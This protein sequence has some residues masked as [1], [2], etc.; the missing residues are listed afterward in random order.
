MS[1]KKIVV[2]LLLILSTTLI[3]FTTSCDNDTGSDISDDNPSNTVGPTD[4]IESERKLYTVKVFSEGG[5]ALT[6]IEVFIYTDNTLKELVWVAKT[7]SEGAVSFT[8]SINANAVILLKNVPS[9]YEYKNEY[10]IEG[11]ITTIKLST[12]LIKLEDM[13]A[14]SFK[15]GDII[16]DFQFKDTD[17]V[18]HKVSEVLK[19]NKAV[20]L[21][22]WYKNCMPCKMEFPHLSAAYDKY[23]DKLELFAMN[24]IDSSAQVIADYKRDNNLSFPMGSCNFNFE[25]MFNLRAYPTTIVI[26]RYG[27]ISF[28]YSGTIPDTE[29]FS[30]IFDY[31]TKDDYVQSIVNSVDDIL[32]KTD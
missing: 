16:C 29:I 3:I 7:N 26:D 14:Q 28:I 2:V 32:R 15:K 12:A 10:H 13:S 18:V 1:I 21:N 20:V 30:S 27:M 24:P 5:M 22:F 31:Y 17:G 11:A 25:S 23:S 8:D 9:G 4:S 6:D 19:S